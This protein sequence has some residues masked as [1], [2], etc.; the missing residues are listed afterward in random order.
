VSDKI[1]AQRKGNEMTTEDIGV[2]P[3]EER[4]DPCA[5][6]TN[7]A[8][9]IA[10]GDTE[11]DCRSCLLAPVTQ[12]YRDEL[13]ARGLGD[14]AKELETMAETSQPAELAQKLDE[15]RDKVPE[16]VKNRLKDFDCAAQLHTEEPK[17]E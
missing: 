15:I 2:K 5:C 17:D 9:W 3:E 13:K 1:S 16:E 6:V 10:Q 7:M 4:E 14:L 12:W 11:E 8:E